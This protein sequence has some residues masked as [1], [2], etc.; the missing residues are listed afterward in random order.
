MLLLE[1]HKDNFDVLLHYGYFR[2]ALDSFIL[3]CNILVRNKAIHKNMFAVLLSTHLK[4]P[5]PRTIFGTSG[6]LNVFAPFS[7][8]TPVFFSLSIS[9][10]EKNM[11]KKQF[12]AT[13]PTKIH[14]VG[15]QKKKIR[16][17][18]G[19]VSPQ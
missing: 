5:V 11:K 3:Y 18:D 10:R 2:G 14:M 4:P 16:M 13:Y 8:V 19:F 6:R 1:D 9:E 7:S 17:A 15:V 12:L